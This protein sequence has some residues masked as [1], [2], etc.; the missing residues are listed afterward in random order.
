LTTLASAIAAFR[1]RNPAPA[2]F[3]A[4]A[5]D[6][7]ALAR[8]DPLNAGFYVL[9]GLLA[10]DFTDKSEGQP[11][12]SSA[13]LEAKADL[14]AQAER[15]APALSLGAEAK[16]ALLNDLAHALACGR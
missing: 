14:S 2:A 12:T 9:L 3:E 6:C 11:L 5:Q 8:T 10:R 4:F 16:L 1:A 13:A 15:V 7:A